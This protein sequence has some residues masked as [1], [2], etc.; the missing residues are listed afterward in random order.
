MAAQVAQELIKEA[1]EYVFRAKRQAGSR[2]ELSN[3]KVV[4]KRLIISTKSLKKK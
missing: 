2:K 3:S 4:K 1:V